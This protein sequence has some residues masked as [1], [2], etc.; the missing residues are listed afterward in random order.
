MST[1]SGENGA[2]S[3][4]DTR[5]GVEE[6]LVTAIRG[7][8]KPVVNTHYLAGELDLPVDETFDRL[9][10]LAGD[11]VVEHMEVQGLGHLWWL[12][13]DSELDE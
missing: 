10:R 1:P 9:D 3:L 2:D 7:A 6:R 12:S 11:E 8:P 5:D 4:N 13:T